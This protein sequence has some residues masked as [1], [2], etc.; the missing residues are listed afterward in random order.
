M[1]NKF[2]SSLCVTL[3]VLLLAGCGKGKEP[4]GS[5]T[6]L[7][8]VNQKGTGLVKDCLL[9]TST[10]DTC[11]KELA[12]VIEV[13][14]KQVTIGGMAKGSGMIHPNM[15]TML[16]FVT[17]DAV[18]AKETLQKALSGDVDDTY[19]MISVDEMCI[20]DS[21]NPVL[22]AASWK[23]PGI[24]AFKAAGHAAPG[25]GSQRIT[26]IRHKAAAV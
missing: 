6:Y 17:T 11:E 3:C 26:D 10:T 25:R 2:W 23:R 19:N 22:S 13:G 16:A 18:I 20:R 14:G 4:D 24:S 21:S 7:Y 8:Y 15:C 5:G 9:Y 1:K 12:A